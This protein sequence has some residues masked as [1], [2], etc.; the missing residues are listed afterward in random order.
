MCN[1][2][3]DQLRYN[4][5][6]HMG[7]ALKLELLGNIKVSCTRTR[8]S[9]TTSSSVFYTTTRWFSAAIQ[10]LHVGK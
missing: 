4:Y 8:N 9:L 7:M 6:L 1:Y 10:Y 2:I 5:K 3:F